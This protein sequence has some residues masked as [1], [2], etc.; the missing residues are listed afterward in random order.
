MTNKTN[1]ALMAQL[2]ATVLAEGNNLPV[3]RI[4][5]TEVHPMGDSLAMLDG[6][7]KAPKATNLDDVRAF[8][9]KIAQAACAETA[10]SDYDRSIDP[11][12]NHCKAASWVVQQKFGGIIVYAKIEGEAHYWNLLPCG[13]QVDVTATQYDAPYKGDGTT[14]VATA[15]HALPY[16]DPK[17]ANRRFR[18]LAKLIDQL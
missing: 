12:H 5:L 10:F 7:C 2:V 17:K 1:R 9:E 3:G 11:M 8:R 16:R 14:P 15:T 13:T 18:L 6:K 4:G